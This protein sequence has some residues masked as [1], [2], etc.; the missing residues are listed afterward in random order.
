MKKNTEENLSRISY[1]SDFESDLIS[2]SELFNTIGG[3]EL[4]HVSD[5]PKIENINFDR[6]SSND[7]LIRKSKGFS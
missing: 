2:L 5:I 4:S 1:Y 7:Y 3:I 6:V